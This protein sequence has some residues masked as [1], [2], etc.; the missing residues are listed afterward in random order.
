MR[1]YRC[2][3]LNDRDRIEGCENVEADALHEAIDRALARA[4][5]AAAEA[6]QGDRD[7][8]RTTPALPV[9]DFYLRPKRQ[10]HPKI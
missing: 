5:A 2:Y 8:G 3:F 9:E 7:L 10:S 6:P 1:V 4:A